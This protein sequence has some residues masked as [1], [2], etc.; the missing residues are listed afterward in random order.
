MARTLTA[1][2]ATK[3]AQKLGTEPILIV[4]IEWGGVPGTRYYSDKAFTLGSIVTEQRLISFGAIDTIE[5]EDSIG[6]VSTSNL[7]LDDKD[8]ALKII[9]ESVIMEGK[10]VIVYQHYEGLT[11]SDIIP[12]F[13]GKTASPI[14]WSEETRQLT[15]D[16]VSEI[17]SEDVGFAPDEND[18]STI[19]EGAKNQPW[20]IVF[21][22]ALNVPAVRVEC[23]AFGT[24]KTPAGDTAT[25]ITVDNGKNFP[26]STSIEI[27]VASVV[28]EG[29]FSGDVF[30]VTT[31]NKPFYTN[32]GIGARPV[33][34]D[35]VNNPRV[36]WI[37]DSSLNV[38]GQYCFIVG[39]GTPES[40]HGLDRTN[41]CV[42]QEG[43]KLYFARAWTL[44]DG[45]DWVVTPGD[46]VGL[47]INETSYEAR[48]D[49]G[50]DLIWKVG[51]GFE[52]VSNIVVRWWFRP[53]SLVYQRGVTDKYVV[54]LGSSTSIKEVRGKRRLPNQNE[55]KIVPIP[56]SYYTVNISDTI[57]GKTCTT[58]SFS[59][60][61]ESLKDQGWTGEVFCT[62]ESDKGSNTSTDVIKHLLDTYTNLITDGASFTSVASEITKYPSHFALQSNDNVLKIIQ[63][64]AWQARLGI[65]ISAGTVTIKYLSKEPVSGDFTL[66]ES[67]TEL[68]SMG[69]TFSEIDNV[70]T[71]IK[72]KWYSDASHTEEKSLVY[73]N[74]IDEFGSRERDV[75]FYI[76]HNESLIQKSL[77]FWGARWSNIWRRVRVKTFLTTLIAELFDTADLAYTDI[78]L[79]QSAS[80]Y[81]IVQEIQHDP[82][83]NSI[84]LLMELPS[85]AGTIVTSSDYWTDDSSDTTPNDPGTGIT[86]ATESEDLQY[87][88]NYLTFS[89]NQ[90]SG[91][92]DNENAISNL[93]VGAT[94]PTSVLDTDIGIGTFLD[95]ALVVKEVSGT[96]RLCLNLDEIY[97]HDGVTNKQAPLNSLLTVREL[98]TQN[99]V[100]IDTTARIYDSLS[101]KVGRFDSLVEVIE[102]SPGNNPVMLS[103][104]AYVYDAT[105]DAYAQLFNLIAIK[106]GLLSL[107]LNGQIWDEDE[108]KVALLDELLKVYTDNQPALKVDAWMAE[109][110]SRQARLNT[111][112]KVDVS[113]LL[114]LFE[115]ARMVDSLGSNIAPFAW[116]RSGGSW[117]PQGAFAQ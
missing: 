115:N 58:I 1:S 106:N 33:L 55:D 39:N 87:V 108:D 18:L 63:E 15:C 112:F 107:N 28:Y 101:D 111:M 20:P 6:N 62:V 116:T 30:T 84:N 68:K 11:E 69:L 21:G 56:E 9:F 53:G 13:K 66:N 109:S 40:S 10:E 100:A 8:K 85:K 32:I 4:K 17:E 92:G 76:Y 77:N 48:G 42:R 50:V 5:S 102:E 47:K 99:S 61:L 60:P 38:A 67:K 74:N 23:P 83:E 64:I 36:V 114:A 110:V 35:D 91:G 37:Q 14:E 24:L 51:I 105:E 72:A 65:R 34:D 57:A 25:S 95:K 16:L 12:I 27:T 44:N 86:P 88:P 43:A 81:G 70:Y 78:T 29:S 117:Y 3:A 7:V 26:Q 2:A 89:V 113:S 31:A 98:A 54:N 59:R 49:W 71:H 97:V 79:L 22:T 45:T 75:E 41:Y 90:N 80:I 104:G 96:P 93:E 46:F 103:D 19:C 73:K 94:D 82:N 52:S